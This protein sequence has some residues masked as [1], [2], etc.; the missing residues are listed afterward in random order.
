MTQAKEAYVAYKNNYKKN[1]KFDPTRVNYSKYTEVQYRNHRICKFSGVVIPQIK[2]KI[3]HIY[4][5]SETY[6]KIER[7][8][9]VT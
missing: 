4:F 6:D 7:N 1:L 3:L 9:K 8:R 5:D 2:L